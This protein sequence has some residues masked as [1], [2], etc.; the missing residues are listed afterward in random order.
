MLYVVEFECTIL[1]SNPVNFPP[2]SA[3]PG[4]PPRRDLDQEQGIAFTQ[5]SERF[6]LRSLLRPPSPAAISH[7]P[8]DPPN[9][10]QRF[11]NICNTCIS[12]TLQLR[13]SS[14]KSEITRQ[15][16]IIEVENGPRP[17][18]TTPGAALRVFH[19]AARR[20]AIE[21][22]SICLCQNPTAGRNSS[23][24]SPPR[25]PLHATSPK[26][27]HIWLPLLKSL[28][29]SPTP[30]NPPDPNPRQAKPAPPATA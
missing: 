21:R 26:G 20:S 8:A 25:S 12:N 15:N 22:K 10:F 19:F 17:H 7:K 27:E 14:G 9:P 24:K 18:L 6:A 5:S 11:Q 30:G 3:L 29:I 2:S 16:R 1:I 28:P 23:T 13:Q 4:D